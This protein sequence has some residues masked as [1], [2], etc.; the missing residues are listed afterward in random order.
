MA[1]SH[2][3]LELVFV[4]GILT[5]MG[6]GSSTPPTLY[7]DNDGALMLARDRRSCHRS[8][9]I[10]RRYLKVREFVEQGKISVESIHT[11]CNPADL[12]TKALDHAKF[13]KFADVVMDTSSTPP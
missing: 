7:I 6:I 8:R 2:C 5:E 13:T 1:A 10:E 9:H 3:A 4:Q 11:D 12:F